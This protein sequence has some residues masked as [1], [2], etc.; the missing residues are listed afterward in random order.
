MTEKNVRVTMEAVLKGGDRAAREGK[1]I[2]DSVR[3]PPDTVKRFT[4][5]ERAA[6][7]SGTVFSK[8]ADSVRM[9]NRALA[10]KEGVAALKEQQK[11]A[12]R[13]AR[14]LDGLLGKKKEASFLRGVL[15]GAGLGEFYPSENRSGMLRQ[16][17][18]R[19]VGA[20]G[21]RVGSGL[22]G[23]ASMPFTGLQG[24]TQM[25]SSL[26][27]GGFLAGQLQAGMGQA[28]NALAYIQH[29]DEM[30]QF[31]GTDP[32][33]AGRR[34]AEDFMPAPLDKGRVRREGDRA[35]ARARKFLGAASPY[36]EDA[37]L[38][39]ATKPGDDPERGAARAR[40][41]AEEAEVRRQAKVSEKER[42]RAIKD[43]EHRAKY[44]PIE[45][46]RKAGVP[47]G[48]DANAVLGQAGAFLGTAGFGME[49]FQKQGAQDAFRAALGAQTRFGIGAD[50]TGALVRG[51][52][53]GAL[54]MGG[55]QTE[56]ITKAISNGVSLG[57]TGTDLQ[58]YVSDI[59][60]RIMAFE[61]SGIPVAEESL[62]S[63][64]M[65]LASTLGSNRSMSVAGTFQQAGQ[66]VGSGAGPTNAA[67]FLML[68]EL[69]GYNGGGVDEYVGAMERLEK[70]QFGPD[71]FKR[72][73][74]AA[75][76]NPLA[77]RNLLGKVGVKTSISEARSMQSGQGYGL[78]RERLGLG[79]ENVQDLWS[80]G[81]SNL[82]IASVSGSS[83][84]AAALSNQQLSSGEKML[85]IM[86]K[87]ESVSAN[88]LTNFTR[89]SDE[90]MGA[91]TWAQKMSKELDGVFIKI[92]EVIEWAHKKSVFN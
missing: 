33:R 38:A 56:A 45:F 63:L 21:S 80:Q 44:G 39:G 32:G 12:E 61:Q 85:P 22:V 29:R 5:V 23:A 79:A 19:I 46:M 4:E 50:V 34:M 36:L 40:R 43:A 47:F 84:T 88:M 42:E 70:G 7:R 35:A 86:Q 89:F 2:V 92:K 31:R 25:F 90:M 81:L 51:T 30:A 49:Q 72:F 58:R 26:P 66:R 71:E 14:T 64:Q 24:M 6:A 68:R 8:V 18:G 91:A 78:F 16:G 75:G 41:K 57:L 10:S 73:T 17:A 15:Q 82:G 27:F 37:W 59:A 55:N 83:K 87:M 48:M 65:G 1:K 13:L 52:T 20:T 3:M 62:H 9:L 54:S 60:Q 77:L 11:E 76:G 53:T 67:E 28:Q 69:G 74:A